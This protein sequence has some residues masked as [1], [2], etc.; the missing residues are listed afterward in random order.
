M[1]ATL[2]RDL[3]TSAPG[4]SRQ[5]R[6]AGRRGACP[7]LSAPMP[8]GDGLL[9]RILPVGTMSIAAFQELCAAARAHGNGIIE[10]TARGS[11]QVRGLSD[12]TAPRFAEAIG[13]LRIAADNGVPVLAD[14]LAGLAA[15]E[16]LDAGKL[17]ADV[18]RALVKTALAARL[19]AKVS[20][21]IDGGGTLSLAAVA[22][23]VRLDAE[24]TGGGVAL[25]VGVAGDG[26]DAC[27]LGV[28]SARDG[29]RAAARLLEV[30]AREGREARTR[31]ILAANGTAPFRK[32][33]SDL[34]W[35]RSPHAHKP[36]LRRSRET[37]GTHPLRDGRLARGVGLAFGHADAMA[38]AQLAEAARALGACGVRVAPGRALLVIGLAPEAAGSV[39]AAAENLGFIVEAD[40]P[41]RHVLAC[42]G[43]PI[44]AS[45]HLAARALAPRIAEGAAPYLRSDFI[46]HVSGCA[47]GCAHA[48]AAT[49][50][51]VGAPD[52]CGLIAE[53]TTR[54]APFRT[55]PADELPA[56]VA[57]YARAAEREGSHG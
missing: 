6:R 57:C 22:A 26:A 51:I 10:I 33:I 19:A 2:A 27:S 32:A 41:R 52:G 28:V 20:V 56:A 14:P 53:G 48:K 17:A 29:A 35:P 46:V 16:I 38:L 24:R 50:T 7:G 12:E 9:V 21:V 49:L 36:A 8:T 25:R 18:R 31:D 54:D 34:L 5:Q 55:V 37:I 39:T 11:I 3:A 30:V 4:A 1:T 15:D 40:D 23:D 13:E 47:K 45:A 42:A 44:C 43:A